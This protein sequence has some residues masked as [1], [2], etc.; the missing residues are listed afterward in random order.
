MPRE[1]KDA[2]CVECGDDIRVGPYDARLCDSCLQELVGV[3][4]VYVASDFA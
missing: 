2:A 3:E 4:P 1:L